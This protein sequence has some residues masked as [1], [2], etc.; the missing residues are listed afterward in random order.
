MRCFVHYDSLSYNILE[1]F[2]IHSQGMSIHDI[3]LKKFNLLQCRDMR[4]VLAH[5]KKKELLQSLYPGWYHITKKGREVLATAHN[6][7]INPPELPK[8]L[9]YIKRKSLS[10]KVLETLSL[11]PHGLLVSQLSDKLSI[12]SRRISSV[13]NYLKRTGRCT[14]PKIGRYIITTLGLRILDKAHNRFPATLIG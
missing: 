7:H 10:V 5:L 14:N 11:H 8:N 9:T 6:R 4:G 13:T 12:P 1:A 2:S 3:N